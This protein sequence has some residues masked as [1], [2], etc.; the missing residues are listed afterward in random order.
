MNFLDPAPP[1]MADET[2]VRMSLGHGAQLAHMQCARSSSNEKPT[3]PGNSIF[4]FKVPK[5]ELDAAL[6]VDKSQN[7]NP[8]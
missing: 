3:E 1:L 2:V 8:G 5:G 6:F 7:P 4:S